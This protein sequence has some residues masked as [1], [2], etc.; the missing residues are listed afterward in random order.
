MDDESKYRH[1]NGEDS[2]DR[3]NIQYQYTIIN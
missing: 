1:L 3:H 2:Q